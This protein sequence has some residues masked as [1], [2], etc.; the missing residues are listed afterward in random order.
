LNVTLD[1]KSLARLL[2]Y[3]LRYFCHIVR[4]LRKL[5]E[6]LPLDAATCSQLIEDIDAELRRRKDVSS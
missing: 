6:L 5:D 1:A 4:E 3:S 2:I